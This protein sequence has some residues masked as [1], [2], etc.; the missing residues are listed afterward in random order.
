[1][2]DLGVLDRNTDEGDLRVLR[3]G[4]LHMCQTWL[5]GLLVSRKCIPLWPNLDLA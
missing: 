5:E 3:V 4:R 2:G 1:M